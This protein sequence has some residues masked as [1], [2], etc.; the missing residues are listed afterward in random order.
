MKW[1][2]D[3]KGNRCD[4][5]AI[6]FI[7]HFLSLSGCG[8]AYKCVCFISVYSMNRNADLNWPPQKDE[9]DLQNVLVNQMF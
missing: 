5:L 2:V 8:C 6:A 7:F 4:A 3:H 9:D 1:A